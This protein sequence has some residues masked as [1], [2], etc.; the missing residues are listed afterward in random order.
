MDHK[1]NTSLKNIP[2]LAE[3]TEVAINQMKDHEEGFVLQVESGK[4]DWAAHANDIAGVIH[5]QLAFDDAIKIVMDF[6]EQDQETLV[7]ITTDHGNANPGIIYDKDATKK[8]ESISKYKFTNEY[9][10]N[11]I[12]ADFNIQE[13][14]DHVKNLNGFSLTD[15]EAQQLLGFYKG[16]TKEDGLYNYKHLPFKL[17]SEIQKKHNSVGWISMDHSGDYVELAMYGPGSELLKP[18]VKNTDVHKIMMMQSAVK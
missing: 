11:A 7:I 9:L 1:N 15:D 17:F 12:T 5:D 2:T 13:V 18:F 6:A 14:K 3:M 16:I 4:V 8:F 10:L